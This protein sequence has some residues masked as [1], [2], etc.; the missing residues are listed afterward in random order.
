VLTIDDSRAEPFFRESLQAISLSAVSVRELWRKDEN[1]RTG[2]AR[3]L[4][5]ALAVR[6]LRNLAVAQTVR[7]LDIP[8]ASP[9]LEMISAGGISVRDLQE[10]MRK[11]GMSERT[12]LMLLVE[13]LR[14]AITAENEEIVKEIKTIEPDIALKTLRLEEA[15]GGGM[16]T[17]TIRRGRPSTEARI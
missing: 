2:Y 11:A 8:D 4:V 12:I 10:T 9:Y 7:W 5:R 6:N 16:F 13:I 3:W 1:A 14:S 17:Q 15:R